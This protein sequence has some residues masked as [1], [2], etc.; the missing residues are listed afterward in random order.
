[1]ADTLEQTK[2]DTKGCQLVHKLVLLSDHMLGSLK[3]Q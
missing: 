2:V 3:V 1:M